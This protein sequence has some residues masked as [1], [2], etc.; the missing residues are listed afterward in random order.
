MQ[1][2]NSFPMNMLNKKFFLVMCMAILLISFASAGYLWDNTYRYDE[3][4]KTAVVEN[5]FGLGEDLAE[6]KLTWGDVQTGVG[7]D[8]KVGMFNITFFTNETDAVFDEILLENLKNGK[9]MSRGKKYK[10]K[11]IKQEDAY[12][13]ECEYTANLTPYNCVPVEDGKKDVVEWIPISN[14]KWSFEEG[15]EYE[16][17]IFVDTEQGDYGDWKP[18]L[19]GVVI[20]EWASWNSSLETNLITWFAL[21]ETTGDAVDTIGTS[22]LTEQGS[23]SSASGIKGTSRGN[24][25]TSANYF[26]GAINATLDMDLQTAWSI[27]AWFKVDSDAGNGN[28]QIFHWDA[29]DGSE[30]FGWIGIDGNKLEVNHCHRGVA[31]Q[32]LVGTD[33]VDFDNWNHVV[34]VHSGSGSVIDV[35]L[36]NTDQGD[37]TA[38]STTAGP[39]TKF[40]IGRSEDDVNS[41][42]TDGYIDEI[43]IWQRG[44]SESEI[45]NL[46]NGGLGCTYKACSEDNSPVVTITQPE[47]TRNQTNSTIDFLFDVTDDQA[48]SNVTLFI[49]GVANQTNTSGVNGSY[50]YNINFSDGT[51]TWLVSAY[52]NASQQTNSSSRTFTIDSTAPSLNLTFPTDGYKY[53][54]HSLQ[55]ETTGIFTGYLNWTAN[56]TNL[57]SCNYSI[58]YYDG[59]SFGD[60]A[61]NFSCSTNGTIVNIDADWQNN[62]TLTFC[63]NDSV[64]NRACETRN[65]RTMQ[66][67]EDSGAYSGFVYNETIVEDITQTI[68]YG[69]WTRGDNGTMTEANLTYNGTTS[70]CVVTAYSTQDYQANCSKVTPSVDA[71]ENVTFYLT[72]T[73]DGVNYNSSSRNQTIYNLTGIEVSTTGSCSAGLTE[74]VRLDFKSENNKTA[75]NTTGAYVFRY[76]LS[77][78]SSARI[79]SNNFTNINLLSLCVN[80][81]ISDTFYMGYGEVQY[82]EVNES[83]TERRYYIFEGTRL[84]NE[85]INDTA[86]SLNNGD[87][88]SF[89]F[90]A[91]TTDLEPYVGYYLGLNRWYPELN[92]YDVVELAKTD[93][94]GQSVLKVETEDV[95]Y[96][97]GIYYPNGTLVYLTD[98]FRV[99]CLASPCAYTISVPTESSRT[100]TTWNNLQT[101]LEH[102]ESTGIITFTYND[103]TQVTDNFTLKVYQVT[104]TNDVEICSDTTSG[105]TGVI[106]CNITGYSGTIRATGS[107]T[108]S[109]ETAIISKLFTFFSET[110]NNDMGLFITLIIAVLL[111]LIG[112]FVSPVLAVVL[113]VVGFIPAIFFGILPLSALLALI[114]LGFM[115]IH[116]MRVQ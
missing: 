83:Y 21:N 18:D 60:D 14:P 95:D 10:V 103:P 75:I 5:A 25:Y 115:V 80:T 69:I 6:I 102:N 71:T 76:G 24:D 8:T 98:P 50:E 2:L 3:E 32:E 68:A 52:D 101:S 67:E 107:R 63:A 36:N 49:D 9:K 51:Y 96:R 27:S 77:E 17:G 70:S 20:D 1:K 111:S 105:Y 39:V 42:L 88:T 38:M 19:L 16:V 82:Q 97:I 41:P 112:V 55:D 57:D 4:T 26:D 93:E 90:T 53:I 12:S 37:V 85:T 84:T 62:S 31:C 59:F 13:Y 64:G 87:S 108:A 47:D 28:R 73:L 65:I 116:F 91:Q 106:S 104:G 44:L 35:Y 46:Y 113:A 99:V 23:V 48:V 61:G 56:D 92:S 11:T 33:D 15:V 34:I 81:T 7:I 30:Y 114:V 94:K 66:I 58:S 29:P 43:G 89:L 109:P 74:V 45:S 110:L 100:L 78:N 86:F 22:D 54:N 79:T 72:Y 40:T